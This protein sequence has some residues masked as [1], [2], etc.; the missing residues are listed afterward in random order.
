M[1]KH[2]NQSG[3]E[4]AN[5][6]EQEVLKVRRFEVEPAE[7][8]LELGAVIKTGDYQTARVTVGCA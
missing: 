5:E 8:S 1:Q 6:G 2:L 4:I 3:S 7:V